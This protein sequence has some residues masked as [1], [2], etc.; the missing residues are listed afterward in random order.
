MHNS[1]L[2]A[3]SSQH[4]ARLAFRFSFPFRFIDRFSEIRNG[5]WFWFGFCFWFMQTN[6]LADTVGRFCILRHSRCSALWDEWMAKMVKTADK[7]QTAT[8]TATATAATT[9]T[10]TAMAMAT[11]QSCAV[12]AGFRLI[13]A[14]YKNAHRSHGQHHTP[15]IARGIPTQGDNS[16]CSWNWIFEQTPQEKKGKCADLS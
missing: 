16:H 1:Q 10:T 8:P 15:S 14:G 6:S 7:Q 5:F 2:T 13:A 12:P 3:H 9:A 11:A 4:T